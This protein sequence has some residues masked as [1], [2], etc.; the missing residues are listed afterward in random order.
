MRRILRT[1]LGRPQPAPA[2]AGSTQL[3]M[4]ARFDGATPVESAL[5]PPGYR[6]VAGDRSRHD[7][8]AAL[9]DSSGEFG[10]IDR[11]TFQRELL[12]I[13]LPGGGV[14]IELDGRLVACAAAC[15]A[16]RFAP[17]ALLNYVLV[18]NDARGHGLGRAAS[19]EAMQRA[20]AAGYPG[21]VLQTDDARLGALGMYLALGF[22]PVLD[23]APDAPARWGAVM[24]HLG[25]RLP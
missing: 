24:A 3:R 4:L 9:L 6:I 13:M 8:W 1:L 7:E 19:L 17:Y 20:R 12:S 22:E 15:F 21:I 23:A 25:N 16:K 5:L 18:Q 10:S 2:A 11:K 14:L